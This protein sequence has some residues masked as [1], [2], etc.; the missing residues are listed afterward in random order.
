MRIIAS[1]RIDRKAILVIALSF[2]FGL[3]VEMVPNILSQF[4]ETLRNIFA[5]GITTGGL[6][7]IIANAL[8]RIDEY[9]DNKEEEI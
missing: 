3:S 4:P 9:K 7:A 8:I 1:Q 2:S 5:S 6:T